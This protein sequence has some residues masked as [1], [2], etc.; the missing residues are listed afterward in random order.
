MTA[1]TRKLIHSAFPGRLSS[2]SSQFR[3]NIPFSTPW[4]RPEP[5]V[6]HS[7]LE[8]LLWLYP[9]VEKRLIWDSD[10]AGFGIVDNEQCHPE[11]QTVRDLILRAI[12][13][14]LLPA[15]QQ[16]VLGALDCNP[17]L[18]TSLLTDSTSQLP[19]LVENCPAIAT[20]LLLKLFQQRY[21]VPQTSATTSIVSEKMEQLANEM[22]KILA[23]TDVSLHG[24]E[25]VNK[26]SA[27]VDL[28]GDFIHAYIVNCIQSCESTQDKYVQ[29]RLVRYLSP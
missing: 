9:E 22:L 7:G 10:T 29:S 5:G 1:Y 13:G 19:S 8:D 6:L 26:L 27:A 24:M 3:G 21:A 2:S 11:L 12:R 20:A 16:L 14:P 28:P 25:V 18:A 23:H 4:E 17:R 15:Q